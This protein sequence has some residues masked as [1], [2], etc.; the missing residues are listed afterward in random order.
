MKQTSH[1]LPSEERNFA[2]Y[3]VDSKLRALR[4]YFGRPDADVEQIAALTGLTVE[5]ISTRPHGLG[6]TLHGFS[7]VRTCSLEWRRDTLA[8]KH[9]GEWDYWRDVII[10]FWI[11]G[12]LDGHDPQY[13]V[14]HAH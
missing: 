8:P 10:G 4:Y 6:R 2:A 14:N 12:P 7:A 9:Q 13:L 3:S 1:Q 11:T 5:D